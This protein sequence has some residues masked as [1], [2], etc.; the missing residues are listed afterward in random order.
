MRVNRRIIIHNFI[1]RVNLIG[2]G[3]RERD[4][5]SSAFP[6][7]GAHTYSSVVESEVMERGAKGKGAQ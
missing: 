2:A 1:R 5:A 6:F 7:R 4:C 3:E